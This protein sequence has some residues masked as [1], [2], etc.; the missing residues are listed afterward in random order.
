M[1]DRLVA[2]A[3]EALAARGG[4]GSPGDPEPHIAAIALFRLWSAD[5]IGPG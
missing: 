5:G 4:A 2:V 1:T 3:A